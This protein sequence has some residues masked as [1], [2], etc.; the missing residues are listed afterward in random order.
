MN[1]TTC[2]TPLRDGDGFCGKCGTPTNQTN[3]PVI[4][5]Q[6]GAPPIINAQPRK[7]K[8]FSIALGVLIPAIAAGAFFFLGDCEETEGSMTVQGGP[9]HLQFTFRPTGCAS[10][11]PYGRM[12]ANVHADGNNDGGFYVTRDPT[13][14]TMVE[15]EV[16]GS[17]RN[18]D[19][20]DCTVFPV[21]RDR[22]TTYDIHVEHMD[23]TVNDVRLVEGHAYLQCTLENGTTV[24]GRID[25]SGC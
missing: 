6:Q 7:P 3:V 15:I 16:P 5:A 12:G 8:V 22:C 1:C 18:S 10:M 19:G 17:C 24:R 4:N 21:P 9:Q 20:T 11:Q 14:G 13:R 2:G 23:V 25:F